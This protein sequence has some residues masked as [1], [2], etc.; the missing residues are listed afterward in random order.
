MATNTY[1]LDGNLLSNGECMTVTCADVP[2]ICGSPPPPCDTSCDTPKVICRPMPTRNAIK[3]LGG[4][5]GRYFTFSSTHTDPDWFA[6]AHK[7]SLTLMRMGGDTCCRDFCFAPSGVTS[8]GRIYYAWPKEFML[9]PA[10]YYIAVFAVDGHTHRET[11]LFKPSS[12]VSV[13]MTWGDF[14]S[15]NVNGVH[16]PMMKG[17][18]CA[19]SVCCTHLP[20]AIQEGFVDQATCGDCNVGCN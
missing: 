2:N 14:D 12:Y 9:A 8:D 10:G 18:G 1:S 4:E 5:I 7:M 20:E 3:L 11:V 15:C 16:T 19:P 13:H 6:H 17:C